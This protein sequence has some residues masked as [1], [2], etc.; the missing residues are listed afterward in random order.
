[1]Q[2]RL[3]HRRWLMWILEYHRLC[4]SLHCMLFCH[5]PERVCLSRDDLI[6]FHEDL[7]WIQLFGANQHVESNHHSLFCVGNIKFNGWNSRRPKIRWKYDKLLVFVLGCHVERYHW[8]SGRAFL[9]RISPNSSQQLYWI[10]TWSTF[11]DELISMFEHWRNMWCYDKT[12]I[13]PRV[14]VEVEVHHWNCARPNYFS[15]NYSRRWHYELIWTWLPMYSSGL[16]FGN[17]LLA[18]F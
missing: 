16:C 17:S 10:N 4:L 11:P 18:V 2:K 13:F 12:Y 9:L 5:W 15:S 14:E 6:P 7:V 8:T 3:F 1:M